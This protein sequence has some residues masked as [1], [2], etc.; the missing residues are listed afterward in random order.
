MQA[1]L[2]LH[3]AALSQAQ[4]RRAIDD[5]LERFEDLLTRYRQLEADNFP[6]GPLTAFFDAIDLFEDDC[7]EFLYG[8]LEELRKT[9]GRR[10]IEVGWS[11][12]EIIHLF[13]VLSFRSIHRKHDD[14]QISYQQLRARRRQDPVYK[15]VKRATDRVPTLSFEEAL[16]AFRQVLDVQSQQK[17][18]QPRSAAPPPPL[19]P[20]AHIIPRQQGS[21]SSSSSDQQQQ[22]DA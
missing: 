9:K 14:P 1:P 21:S 6:V 2:V 19:N 18:G 22:Q 20:H 7:K 8:L 10:L 5:C 13:V 12:D 17:Q 3:P 15:Q 4:R 11:T 16:Q